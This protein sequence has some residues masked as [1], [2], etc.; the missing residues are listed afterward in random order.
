M[1]LSRR[2]TGACVALQWSDAQQRYL[3]GLVADPGRATGWTHPWAQRAVSAWARRSIA[4]GVGC[5]AHL[6]ALSSGDG[7]PGDS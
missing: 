1:L 3:C 6:A 4:A 5:D 2:R 7:A